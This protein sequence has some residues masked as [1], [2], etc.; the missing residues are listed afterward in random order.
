[1]TKTTAPI[2]GAQHEL[3]A[4]SPPGRRLPGLSIVLPCYDEQDNVADAI[5]AATAAAAAVTDDYEVLVVDD[6]SRD[7]TAEIASRFAGTDRHVRLVAHPSNRGY[8]AALRSGVRAARMPW[9]FL[10]DA[11]LQFDLRE[12]E[13]FVPYAEQADLIAGWRIRRQD[14]LHRRL[15][16]AAWNW[17]VRHVFNLPLRDVDCAF[18]LVRRD[19]LERI[20][21]TSDGAMISTELVVRAVAAGARV[22]ELGVH[23]RPRVA[24]E[25]SGANPIV[26][27]RAF[28][29]LFALRGRLHAAGA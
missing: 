1:M 22:Q 19:L 28:R 7:S 21:L 10:T 23:H 17:L 5:R 11:D 24:G 26:V 6:G 9:V 12:L 3:G 27:A 2:D 14:P 16:A 13:D 25:Q 18:K 29:E 20:P 4:V 8:G 15:N